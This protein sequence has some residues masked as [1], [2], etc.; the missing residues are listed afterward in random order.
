MISLGSHKAWAK[1]ICIQAVR[2]W[3]NS[4]CIADIEYKIKLR[5]MMN[6]FIL[7][8]IS[9]VLNCSAPHIFVYVFKL[10]VI[11]YIQSINHCDK[12]YTKLK[13]YFKL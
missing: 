11:W 9:I 12:L 5:N 8:D 1:L 2:A 3:S 13:F 6:Y 10:I 7:S 4:I